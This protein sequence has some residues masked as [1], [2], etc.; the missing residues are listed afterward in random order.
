MRNRQN[1]QT[2]NMANVFRA[3]NHPFSLFFECHVNKVTIRYP[4]QSKRKK[5]SFRCS[6]KIDRFQYNINRL[7]KRSLFKMHEKWMPL[8]IYLN[9][10]FQ[11]LRENHV[12]D[13]FCFAKK[14]H[15]DGMIWVVV[16]TLNVHIEWHIYWLNRKH[17]WNEHSR[18][19]NVKK[20]HLK[21]MSH[22]HKK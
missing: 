12:E 18:N 15:A 11:L 21:T 7:K 19:R 8:E 16:F 13:V 3:E 10:L 6:R 5:K 22:T 9:I 14:F 1:Q 20:W 17:D 2:T 4:R